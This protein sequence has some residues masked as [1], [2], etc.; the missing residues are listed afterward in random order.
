[1]KT[2]STILTIAIVLSLLSCKKK[3]NAPEVLEPRKLLTKITRVDFLEL[4]LPLSRMT[5]NLDS[6]S[7]MNIR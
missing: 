6:K 5:T 4:D 1:M 7:S 2:Y 3:E